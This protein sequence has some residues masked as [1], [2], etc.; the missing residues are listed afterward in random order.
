MRAGT[1]MAAAV[2][3]TVVVVV[4]SQQK[5]F[6]LEALEH[7]ATRVVE[8]LIVVAAAAYNSW[9]T[10]RPSHSRRIPTGVGDDVS[11]GDASAWP[12]R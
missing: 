2:P 5:S 6:D 4:G 3:V 11:D 7:A 1:S 10:N 12:Q 9:A 8:A